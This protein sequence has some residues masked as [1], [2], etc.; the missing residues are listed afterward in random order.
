MFE[1][2]LKL[3]AV[4]APRCPF[5]KAGDR[6]AWDALPG[7]CRAA[8]ARLAEDYRAVEYPVLK[9]SQFMA[10]GRAGDRRAWEEP[11]FLRRRK[12]CAALLGICVSG[13]FSGS[14]RHPE[15][16]EHLIRPCGPPSPRGEGF[17]GEGLPPG[18]KL[19]AKQTDEGV[20]PQLSGKGHFSAL[21]DV[22]D[23]IWLVCEESSWVL[24]AHNGSDHPG[25]R[26]ASERLLPDVGDPYID[27][28]AAQTAMILSL[29]C[30][31]LG[32][33]LDAAAPLIR[34]RVRRE[35]EGRVLHPFETRDDFWWMGITRRDLC[36]W[37]PWIV[38]NVMLTACV[39]M[40][41]RLRLGEALRRGCQML[42]RYVA[43]IPP[44]GGCDEGPG[45]WSMAGGA[46]LDC[47][48]ILEDVAG[49]ALWDDPKL[50]A[51][52]RFPM[53]A[54]LGGRWFINFADCDA[55]PEIPGERLQ[56]AGEKL[57]D[58]AL[59]AF[60]ERFRGDPARML[61]DTPQLWRLLNELFRPRT[62]AGES[63]PPGDVWLPDMQVRV[64]RSGGMTMACKGGVNEG[65]HNHNDCGSFMLYVDG[66][67]VIVDAGNMTYTG[68]T[69]SRERYTLWNTRAMYHNIPLIGGVE[70]VNGWE[71]R[72]KDA[73]RTRTGMTMELSDAYPLDGLR[74]Q[75]TLSLDG[76]L[77]LTDRIHTDAP[78]AV[79]EVFLLRH[80]PRIEGGDA[81][82]GGVRIAPDRPMRVGV[83][84][85]P[86]TD[87][88]MARHFPGSLWRVT[89]TDAAAEEH[90]LRFAVERETGICG[91]EAPHPNSCRVH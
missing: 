90:V 26:P 30:A 57:N 73:C 16:S 77:T 80:P 89:F 84:E 28:F 86:V 34:R 88:R 85:I 17:T 43:V 40:D 62:E 33:A 55:M 52:M 15:E 64:V 66:A 46:L 41:D 74:F 58:P 49:V 14:S 87:P 37:T 91:A 61:E 12:L 83:E 23:G 45:Y 6:A 78:A 5:P 21:D 56:F 32:E 54:W 13:D 60:G 36:N 8:L 31:L 69:F 27:L 1:K 67:P 10:F 11:Y 65:S 75:R 25:Q 47:L 68:V 70:Q 24:S 76:A 82:S 19:S 39:W 51:I 63:A 53:N 22:I 7:D 44:D 2:Y 3:S 42:E 50:Q 59:R 81:L 35:I 48:S 38:S 4:A 72:A 79:T 29:T 9:A 18:G 71:R 20:V